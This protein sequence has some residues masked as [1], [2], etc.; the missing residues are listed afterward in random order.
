MS[1]PLLLVSHPLC[2]YVQRCAIALSEK[3]VPF[4][5]QTVDLAARPAWFAAISPLGKVPLL[6]VGDTTLFESAAIVEYIEDTQPRPLHPADPLVRAE[7]RGWM[8]FGSGLLADIAG[9]YGAAEETAFGA[10]RRTI[11]DKLARLEARLGKGP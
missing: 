1:S 6:R 7:H 8:E 11:L 4:E 10:R 3:G 9:L 2:P 5:R